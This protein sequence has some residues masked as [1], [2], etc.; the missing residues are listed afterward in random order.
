MKNEVQKTNKKI[1]RIGQQQENSGKQRQN[2]Q[3]NPDSTRTVLSPINCRDCESASSHV[4]AIGKVKY[5]TQV[6]RKYQRTQWEGIVKVHTE[7]QEFLADNV[8][9]VIYLGNTTAL[10]ANQRSFQTK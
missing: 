9:D 2:H 4:L 8:D 7:S 1:G 5:K 10:D 3:L 6:A